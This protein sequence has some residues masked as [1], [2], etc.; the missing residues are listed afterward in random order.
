[1]TSSEQIIKTAPSHA[2]DAVRRMTAAASAFLNT[3]RP[4]QRAEAVF[5][6]KGDERYEWAY[7]PIERN[8]LRVRNMTAEQRDAAIRMMDTAYSERGIKTAHQ[9]MELETILGEWEKMS[10][11]PSHWER[12]LDRYWFSVFGTPGSS[13][14]WGFRAGGHHIGL[15]I[16][17]VNGELVAYNPLFFGANPAQ[18][19]HGEHKGLRT[20]PEEEDWAR[21]LVKSMSPDQK[22]IAIVDPVAPADILTRNYRVADPKAAPVGISFSALS[23]PQRKDLVKLVRRYVTRAA[24]D[25]AANY[26]KH[27]ESVGMDRWSFAWAGP[28]A[29][30]EGHYYSIQAPNF[31]VE[32]DN[33]QNGANH[34]HSV[35]RDFSNDF[36]ED[37]LAAHYK[38]SA[39]HNGH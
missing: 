3:L 39:H 20:L 29:V 33:T 22:K 32:Y 9:I 28:E 38:H 21:A 35:L 30:G 18:V 36:G 27:I 12:N 31:V 10:G 8:G 13:E 26:W 37:I 11:E 16:T 2:P 5:P 4:E 6:F 34:I 17:V 7:T 15:C 14:P 24:D 19:R 1:M 25:I 23:D